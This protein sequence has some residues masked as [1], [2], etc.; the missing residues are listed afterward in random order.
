MLRFGV[1]L[2]TWILVVAL[3]TPVSHAQAERTPTPTEAQKSSQPTKLLTAP[4]AIG[5]SLLFLF[6]IAAIDVVHRELAH[7]GKTPENLSPKQWAELVATACWQIVN[8]G[9]TWTAMAA[10]SAS[11]AAVQMPMKVMG[12]LLSTPEGKNHFVSLLKTSVMHSVSFLA[13][14]SFSQL[15]TEATLLVESKEDYERLNSILS[16]SAGSFFTL[17][18]SQ[19]STNNKDHELAKKMLANMLTVLTQSEKRAH[20]FDR[21]WRMRIMTG[22]FWSFLSASVATATLGTLLFP[23]AGTLVGWMFGVMGGAVTVFLPQA[24]K[25]E[26]TSSLR[27][28]RSG[29]ANAQLRGNMVALEAAIDRIRFPN[30]VPEKKRLRNITTLLLERRKLREQIAT[31]TFEHVHFSLKKTKESGASSRSATQHLQ[32]LI[33]LWNSEQTVLTNLSETVDLP[34]QVDLQWKL[35]IT[36]LST[37]QV[38]VTSLAQ[39]LDSLGTALFIGKLSKE[40]MSLARFVETNYLQGFEEGKLAQSFPTPATK[41]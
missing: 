5:Q 6:S 22:E 35:E 16:V 14:E 2:I 1:R 7:Q 30:A 3:A 39:E 41:N 13:W 38:L 8:T 37:L 33:D 40:Q 28:L 12:Q 21:T 27:G 9:S 18:G 4:V 10:A 25:D 29:I 23:G 32:N 26:I 36:R 11:S 24:M 34:A 15:W 19:D 17:L 20:W 31:I